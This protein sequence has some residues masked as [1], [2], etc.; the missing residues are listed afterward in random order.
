[1]N[2]SADIKNEFLRSKIGIAG[3]FILLILFAVSIF[4]IISIPSETFQNWNNPEK[5]VSYPKT[6][7][8][9]WV[10]LFMLEKIPEH[11]IL[12]PENITNQNDEIFLTSNQFRFNYEFGD[13]PSDFMYN[14][15]LEYTGSPLLEIIVIKP[16]GTILELIHTSIP[17]STELTNYEQRIFSA[18]DLLRKMKIY[19][20]GIYMKVEISSEKW[21]FTPRVGP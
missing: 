7:V 2:T 5:W 17:H 11:K 13:F 1:M 6:S 12:V 8:P 3:I 14:F 9:S 21:I 18:D 19:T 4:A 16:D 15:N 10:N 20:D